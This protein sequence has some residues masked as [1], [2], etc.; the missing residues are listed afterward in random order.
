[1]QCILVIKGIN[2]EF[3]EGL[4]QEIPTYNAVIQDKTNRYVI[5][6]KFVSFFK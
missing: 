1:M 4:K 5:R 6:F 3:F 2:I